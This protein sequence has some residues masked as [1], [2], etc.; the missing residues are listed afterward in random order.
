M[1]PLFLNFYVLEKGDI[2][3]YE[4]EAGNDR[5]EVRLEQDTVWRRKF[6]CRSFFGKPDKTS[7]FTLKIYF[8]EELPR[9][10]LSRNS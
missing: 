8:K 9:R 2:I 10:Q 7:A 3:F 6:K 5:I 4:A 1:S